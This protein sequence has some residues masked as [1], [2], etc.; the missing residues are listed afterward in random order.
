M[1]KTSVFLE[2]AEKMEKLKHH[3]SFCGINDFLSAESTK[4]MRDN[5]VQY[6]DTKIDGND[7]FDAYESAQLILLLAHEIYTSPCW[8][9]KERR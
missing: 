5:V 2:L 6:G 3:N 9:D 4:W 7:H 8:N 1:P